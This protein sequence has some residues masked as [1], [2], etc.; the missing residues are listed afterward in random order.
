MNGQ[1][2]KR[3]VY[4]PIG[5]FH[6]GYSG[7]TAA[8]RQGRFVPDNKGKIEIYPQFRESLFRL[9]E[10]E[11]ILVIYHLHQVRDWDPMVVPPGSKTGQA[12]GLFATRTPRR[13]NPIGFSVIKLDK[14]QD[15]VLYVS[16]VDA[17]DGTPVLDIK[18]YLPAIDCVES[19][20]NESLER[21]MGMSPDNK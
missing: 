12:Y 8:P 19:K 1:D 20:Q 16:G 14:I 11:Y 15:G 2:I 7:S 13:P 4:K 21:N 3:V 17:F 9:D 10:Y 5:V 18:P 6:T